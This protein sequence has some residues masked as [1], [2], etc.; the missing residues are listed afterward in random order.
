MVN[1]EIINLSNNKINKIH[2]ETFKGL[3]KLQMVLLHSNR[4]MKNND[5][6][7]CFYLEHDFFISVRNIIS[8]ELSPPKQIYTE[9]SS[10]KQNEYC[11]LLKRINRDDADKPNIELL[12]HI[13]NDRD[14]MIIN[15][16]N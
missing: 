4:L 1:L 2:D 11:L 6:K 16:V 8:D 9:K 7:L 10:L 13:Q 12:S 15:K 3:N 5:E 14:K